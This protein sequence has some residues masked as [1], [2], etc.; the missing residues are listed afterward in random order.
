MDS[1]LQA[2]IPAVDPPH[3]FGLT[4]SSTLPSQSLSTPSHCSVDAL[5]LDIEPDDDEPD[6]VEPALIA[7]GFA[8]AP[9]EAP[10]VVSPV[11][12]ASV[13]VPSTEDELIPFPASASCE[14]MGTHLPPTS[15]VPMRH[16][17]LHP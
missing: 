15:F 3:G 5:Q 6:A 17:G 10:L 11:V 16:S 1:L 14:V 13:F 12:P 4:S 9:A 8:I 7:A 2:P